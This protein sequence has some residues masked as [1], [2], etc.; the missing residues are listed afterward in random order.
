MRPL[1]RHLGRAGL[2]LLLVAA[3]NRDLSLPP[4]QVGSVRGTLEARAAPLPEALLVLTAESGTRLEVTTAADGAFAADGLAPGLWTAT[5]AVAGYLPLEKPFTI[6]AGQVRELGTLRLY[7]EA[8]EAESAGTVR[9]RVRVDGADDAAV[10][11]ATIE[12]LLQ[13]DLR[14]LATTAVGANGL[15]AMQL[16]PGSYSLRASHPYFVTTLKGDITVAPR[17]EAVLADDALL[18]ALNPGRLTGRVLR[19]VDGDA[20]PEPASGVTV[21]AD[22]GSST[23]TAPDGTFELAGLPGGARRLRFALA[24]LHEALPNRVEEVTAGGTADLGDVA[25]LL[26]RGDAVGTVEMGDG[27]PLRDVTLSIDGTAYSAA[28]APSSSDPMRGS[29]RVSGIPV[30]TYT[31]TA[32][33]SGYRSASSG[34]FT[35]VANQAVT[36]PP[37][38]R[39]TRVQGDFVIDDGDPT[40]SPGF[41]RR[42]AVTLVVNTPSGVAGW[43]AAE[44]DPSAL[45]FEPFGADGGTSIPFTLTSSEGEKTVFLQLRDGAGNVGPVLSSTVVLDATA[46]S[47][48]AL[49]LADGTGFTSQANP[50]PFSLS[51]TDPASAGQASGLAFMRL[52]ISS[53]VDAQGHLSGPRLAY[54]R[55]DSFTRPSSSD[56]P[57]T[58]YGQ[59]I[60]HAGNVSAPTSA[61]VVVDTQSPTGSLTIQRG[62]GATLDGYTA[63]PLVTL[64]LAAASEPHG[65]TVR[66]RVANDATGVDVATPVAAAAALG[67]FLDP[68]SD[69]TRTVYVRFLD[70]AGNQSGTQ[71]ATITLDRLAPA[72][73][74]PATTLA[75]L[76]TPAITSSRG[77]AMATTV[78]DERRLSPTEAALVEVDGLATT[79]PPTST[80][81]F[82]SS[83]PFTLP[84]ADGAHVVRVRFKDAAGNV[85]A[86]VETTVTLDRQA[87]SGTLALQ[88]TL[89]DGTPS[90]SRTATSIVRVAVTA[91]GADAV[92]LTTGALTTCPGSGGAWIALGD[93]S[94]EAFNLGGTPGT[95]TLR[96]CLR[97]AAGNTVLLSPASIVVDGSAPAGCALQLSGTRRDGTA[98]PAGLTAAASVTASLAGCTEAPT[99][100]FVSSSGAAVTCSNAMS[101][102]WLPVAALSPLALPAVDATHTVRGCVRDATR[103]VG[104]L[105]QA[106]ITLDT[107]PPSAAAVSIN[108]DAPS[109]N[110]SQV[111]G[112]TH[113]ASLTGVASGATEWAVGTAPGPTN[114]LAFPGTSPRT[115]PIALAADAAVTVYARFRDAVGNEVTASDSII[116]D[117]TAPSAPGVTVRPTGDPGFVNSE[118]V[119]LQL[120]STAGAQAAQVAEGASAS[121]CTTALDS[122]PQQPPLNALTFVLSPVDGARYVCARTQDAAGNLSP[123]SSAV[124]TLDRVAPSRPAIT[125]PDGYAALA[126]GASAAI[127]IASAA[128]DA[129]LKGYERLGG[130]ASAWTAVVPA[131][132]ATR[133]LLPVVNDGSE[134][135][136]RNELRLRAVDRAGNASPESIVFVTADTNA[137]E[138]ATVDLRWVDNADRQSTV[139]WLAPDAGDLAHYEI[140]YDNAPLDTLAGT[141][142]AE[143]VSPLLVAATGAS[144]SATLSGLVNESTSYVRVVP[145]D[146]A[147][148]RGPADAG[149]V[150]LQPN[151]LSPNLLASISLTPATHGWALEHAEGYLYVAT[152][153]HPIIN[154][155]IP[156]G[157]A[158]TGDARLE[159][160]D[161]RRLVAPVQ[162][163]RITGAAAPARTAEFTFPSAMD[164]N[165]LSGHLV[166]IRVDQPWLFLAYENVVHVYSL[167]NPAVPQFKTTLTLPPNMVKPQ[168]EVV[169]DTLLISGHANQAYAVSLAALHDNAAATAPAF[170]ASS[171]GIVDAGVWNLGAAFITR[172]VLVHQDVNSQVT[173]FRLTDAL[174]D[175]A[176]TL[177]DQ[178][179]VLFSKQSL[180]L[181]P[182]TRP[183]V[184]GNLAFFAN[185]TSDFSVL[186]LAP[187]W[188][189]AAPLT[190]SLTRLFGVQGLLRFA[191]EG[192]EL[193]VADPGARGLRVYDTSDLGSPY[194]VTY[195][196][197]GKPNATHT[198]VFGTYAAVLSNTQGGSFEPPMLSILELATPRSLNVE[199]ALTSTGQGAPWVRPG[200]AVVSGWPT[201]YDL[202]SGA[203][204]ASLNEWGVVNHCLTGSTHFEETEVQATGA[205]VRVVD[206]ETL[207]DRD[208][209]TTLPG[210]AQYFANHPTAGVVIT[211]VAA[212]GN[213]LVTA[214]TRASGQQLWLEV[215]D[216]RNLRDHNTATQLSLASPVAALQVYSAPSASTARQATV[217][218]SEG[219]A[220]LTFQDNPTSLSSSGRVFVVDLAP[221]FDDNSGTV[222][223]AAQVQANF[224]MPT[225]PDG[226]AVLPRAAALSVDTVYV[227]G[228]RGMWAFPAAEVRDGNAGT[229]TTGAGGTVSLPGY[230]FDDVK[231][232]GSYVFGAP[233]DYGVTQ[234]LVAF[235][236]SRAPTDLR[237]VGMAT[238]QAPSNAQNTCIT[239][240]DSTSRRLRGGL[241]VTG[242]RAYVRSPRQF[243]KLSIVKL[244]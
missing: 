121:A 3:C 8:A 103:N 150:A 83:L 171:E 141:Y 10:Q 123:P 18:L 22:N 117:L 214:E 233:G 84:D 215:F 38:A 138:P 181:Q 219:F 91:S 184:S 157:C 5:A 216:A 39:L 239:P 21:S 177:W 162:A 47:G 190:A 236:T 46:P 158:V 17:S 151:E 119:T 152:S 220:T 147:G 104:A 111:S 55:D 9:G 180:S 82:T 109:I 240:I 93:P 148:N 56:G 110:A 206:L 118:V 222:L 166:D 200:F 242:S 45:P 208:V 183:V 63:T 213:Y 1:P 120:A 33:R 132:P 185:G 89:A 230:P 101:A 32:V 243:G 217:S 226:G 115:L 169:G 164:C 122:A 194:P 42:A 137:P 87:P 25:M 156:P 70:S 97:D 28:A 62:P 99:E 78:S 81:T 48:L 34:A 31:L 189:G 79:L 29:F 43:R 106:T 12:A 197:L 20:T 211:D 221:A 94:L 196:D 161:V 65:G 153:R 100:V 41:T 204:P 16:P 193:Y 127:D 98:A 203:P 73:L 209:A 105:G 68:Q 144:M 36:V 135:G 188:S 67:W 145:V 229:T 201:V 128:T 50:L 77:G 4:P 30:G 175:N 223:G 176:G 228:S 143:G 66:V 155:S 52:S 167:I 11:G 61:T 187:L 131:G 160:F 134:E 112:G 231:V 2:S 13:P 72:P 107:T 172:N 212:W 163:G 174:D 207:L 224:A 168:L 195:F 232:T 86:P 108:L 165:G 40:N 170:P 198:V 51:G 186:P 59:L 64:L 192:S 244:E 140:S 54:Q 116:A 178:T 199:A 69:G 76:A 90:S 149:V 49:R 133:F 154:P 7:A 95:V 191:L 58:L 136:L 14:L 126:D 113:Q 129:N 37:L 85:S 15:F 114:F 6:S 92:H 27:S 125:T 23:S 80:T 60:D 234:A 205:Q 24:G 71:S 74:A 124:V 96:G 26:D 241:V 146:R 173:A 35:V 130:T 218:V 179:D 102:A 159:V 227:A 139:Y 88:G 182:N 235:D 44:G 210:A 142:A 238:L 202:H 225:A 19:E 75:S 237:V 57:V 53:M